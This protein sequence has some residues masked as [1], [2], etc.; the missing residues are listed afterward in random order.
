MSEENTPVENDPKV[1]IPKLEVLPGLRKEL[2]LNYTVV[3]VAELF[4]ENFLT[5]ISKLRRISLPVHQRK[6]LKD[7]CLLLDS[8]YKSYNEEKNELIKQYGTLDEKT[9]HYNVSI[10]DLTEEK[11]AEFI[12]DW[13]E[14]HSIGVETGLKEKFVLPASEAT[15]S[16]DESEIIERFLR[17]P[18]ENRL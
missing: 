5:A 17:I 2:F 11:R 7:F 1:E 16:L 10:N 12:K 14:L 3:T 8:N 4:N 6:I 15:L 9:G 13:D 18:G